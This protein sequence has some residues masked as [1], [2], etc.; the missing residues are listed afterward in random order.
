MT[1]VIDNTSKA[2]RDTSSLSKRLFSQSGVTLLNT[3][4]ID[5]GWIDMSAVSKY[6]I[7]YFGS[8]VLSLSIESREGDS[9]SAELATPATFSGAFYLADL[10]PRQKWIR[11]ILTN[12]TGVTVTNVS[13]GVGGIYGGLDGASVFPLE[14]A[15]SQFSPAMLVQSVQTGLDP[16]GVY[17]NTSVNEAG[18]SLVADFG[19]EVARNLY[20]DYSITRKFGRNPDVDVASTPEDVFDGGGTYSGFNATANENLAVVSSSTADVGGLVSSG[21]ST[22]GSTTTI[23]DS[24]ATFVSDGVAVDDAVLLDGA[25]YHG[26]V[27]SIDSETQIT[28][29]NWLNGDSG[30]YAA[31]SG[32]TYRVATAS[33][34]GAAVLRV[35]RLLNE[36][37]ESQTNAYV[38]LNGTTTVSHAG[39]YMRASTGRVVL[40]GSGGVNAGTLTCNQAVTVANVFFTLPIGLGRTTTGMSTIPRGVNGII[41]RTTVSITRANGSLGSALVALF[42]RERGSS[43]FTALKVFD[44]STSGEVNRTDLGG[45]IIL[46]GTDY[47]FTVISVSDNNTIVNAEIEHFNITEA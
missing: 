26:F 44:I 39:D 40:S 46:G 35:S 27:S 25:G 14:I 42:V 20:S 31:T 43:T 6:Q 5:T 8:G 37:F 3:E 18:A 32:V 47:K 19:T 36:N 7:S 9:G 13:F 11:L 28:V 1:S 33:S 45:D 15:P 30:N 22:G 34:T 23:I 4:S 16:F 21:T 29:Y 10:P 12:D 38:I 24:G 2:I 17:K 41:K